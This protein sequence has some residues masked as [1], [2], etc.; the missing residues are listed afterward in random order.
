MPEIKDPAQR[1]GRRRPVNEIRTASPG[2][3]HGRRPAPPRGL[4]PE[5]R[6]TWRSWFDSLAAAFWHPGDMPGLVITIRL[7]DH[8]LTKPSAATATALAR[9]MH[10]YG[11]TPAGLQARHW[12][13][14]T[15][16]ESTEPASKRD[17]NRYRSLKVVG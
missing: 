4:S 10:D 15:G 11:L 8:Q 6:E 3:K 2:W 9:W 12:R 5:A 17:T 14:S 1:R 16:S 7:Y 13:P